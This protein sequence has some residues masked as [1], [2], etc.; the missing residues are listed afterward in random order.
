MR[1][2]TKLATVAI[3]VATLISSAF[4]FSVSNSGWGIDDNGSSTD[5]ELVMEAEKDWGGSW[6]QADFSNDE[7]ACA[8][9]DIKVVIPEAVDAGTLVAKFG[10]TSKDDLAILATA[11][12]TEYVISIPVADWTA[13]GGEKKD[14]EDGTGYTVGGNCQVAAAGTIVYVTA[15]KPY[16]EP[17][18]PAV[19]SSS[20]SS[21]SV[22]ESSSSTA[23]DTATKTGD[24]TS[25]AVL[26]VIALIALGGVVVTSKKRA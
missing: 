6:V 14:F 23:D 3:S 19:E 2:F 11:G 16:P 26:A 17:A 5:T 21:S 1:K 24:A 20:S 15:N 12:Q 10:D 25:V 13:K 8:T 18:A 9:M 4:A 7:D 22:E